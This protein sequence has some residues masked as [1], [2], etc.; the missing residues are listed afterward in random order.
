MAKTLHTA[1]IAYGRLH[2]RYSDLAQDG[3][4]LSRLLGTAQIYHDASGMGDMATR[5]CRQFRRAMRAGG[6][7]VR[8]PG[9]TFIKPG[10]QAP[11]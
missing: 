10:S 3:N 2:A 7:G 8:K 9:A 11:H 5:R 6:E 4:K 1:R